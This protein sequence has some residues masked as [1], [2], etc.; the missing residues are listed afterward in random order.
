[1]Y[2]T[3]SAATA[4]AIAAGAQQYHIYPKLK[5]K[6]VQFG[7]EVLTEATFATVADP[8]PEAPAKDVAPRT[9]KRP[10]KGVCADVW[11]W[12]DVNQPTTAAQVRAH[13][14]TVGWNAN[15]CTTEYYGWRRASAH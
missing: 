9:Y 5:G 2:A 6:K 7:Y 4:A 14:E 15:N 3:R 11:A 10:A 8:A 1:M 12:C 13:G